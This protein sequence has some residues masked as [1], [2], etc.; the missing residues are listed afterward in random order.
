M[1]LRQLEYLTALAREQHFGR[2]AAACNV[3]RPTL[4]EA[5]RQLERELGVPL[6][7]RNGRRFGGLTPEGGRILGW[8]QEILANEDALRQEL[9]VEMAT[10]H[11]AKR[12]L[13][14]AQPLVGD[15]QDFDLGAESPVLPGRHLPLHR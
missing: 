10:Q 11:T 6:I 5:V 12:V 1:F 4:S 8:A 9:G 15:H 2:A 14:Q 7:D 3:T 13:E